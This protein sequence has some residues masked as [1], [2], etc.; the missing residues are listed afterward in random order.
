MVAFHKEFRVSTTLAGESMFRN[1]IPET[2]TPSCLC[3]R[4]EAIRVEPK[5]VTP[6]ALTREL[7]AA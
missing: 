5:K 2:L 4:D 3:K 6:I 7:L 1:K